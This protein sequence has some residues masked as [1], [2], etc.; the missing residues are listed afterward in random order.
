MFIRSFKK[1]IIGEK[2]TFGWWA[3]LLSDATEIF[4]PKSSDQHII[5]AM[6]DQPRYNYIDINELI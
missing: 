3:A 1:I 5:Q 2:S 4:V 6:V